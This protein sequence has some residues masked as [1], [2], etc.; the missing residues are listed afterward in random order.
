MKLPQT[1]RF[2]IE[3]EGFAAFL[4]RGVNYRF[5][6]INGIVL[7]FVLE[8]VQDLVKKKIFS[9]KQLGDID[10]QVRIDAGWDI[11]IK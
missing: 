7:F 4:L 1:R 10:G 8:F 3:K 6:S 2:L 5:V 11:I 9:C